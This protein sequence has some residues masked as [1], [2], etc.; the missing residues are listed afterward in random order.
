MCMYK[1]KGLDAALRQ[2]SHTYNKFILQESSGRRGPVCRQRLF[3]CPSTNLIFLRVCR[4][5]RLVPGPLGHT[6]A[7]S[8][9]WCRVHLDTDFQYRKNSCAKQ[10]LLFYSVMASETVL[11]YCRAG[12]A[13]RPARHTT[14]RHVMGDRDY[15]QYFGKRMTDEEYEEFCRGLKEDLHRI[16]QLDDEEQETLEVAKLFARL[17]GHQID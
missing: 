15:T 3:L 7:Q 9:K 8:V 10:R 17:N 6:C 12:A 13:H 1:L 2:E 5:A 14:E 11:E 16:A 4:P